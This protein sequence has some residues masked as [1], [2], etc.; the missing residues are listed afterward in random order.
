[1]STST[2]DP[3]PSARDAP[4]AWSFESATAAQRA[5]NPI[6]EEDAQFANQFPV[7][8]VLTR[9]V[10]LQRSPRAASPKR[11]VKAAPASAKTAPPVPTAARAAK[12]RPKPTPCPATG[13]RLGKKPLKAR[14]EDADAGKGDLREERAR[15]DRCAGV[16]TAPRTRDFTRTVF[17]EIAEESFKVRRV[18]RKKAKPAPAKAKVKTT[19]AAQLRFKFIRN[20]DVASSVTE[21][22]M[23][24]YRKPPFK[25]VGV[26]RLCYEKLSEKLEKLKI[27]KARSKSPAKGKARTKKK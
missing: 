15:F 3:T 17:S 16:D 12:S 27:R 24:K 7:E 26:L 22:H 21:A 10:I 6:A 5:L 11:A 4:T 20:Q 8:Q 19:K 18:R 25:T 13:C 9:T 1:M 2:G 23:K 14:D